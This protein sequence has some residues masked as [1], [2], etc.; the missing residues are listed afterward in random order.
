M[1]EEDASVK[2]RAHRLF[3]L[4]AVVAA[5]ALPAAAL[6][7]T[8]AGVNRGVVQSVDASHI[9]VTRPGREHDHVRRLAAA[10]RAPQRPPRLAGRDHAG[11]RGRRGRRP[12]GRAVLIRAFGAQAS[13]TERGIVTAVTKTSLTISTAAGPDDRPRPQY[14]LQGAGW[15]RQA[16]RRSGSACPSPSRTHPTAPRR[17]STCSSARGRDRRRSAERHD[18]SRRGRG[19]HRQPRP[20]ISRERRLPGDLG[21]ARR[22]GRA[23]ARAARD[24][25]RD[26]RPAAA[27]RGRA[28]PLPADPADVATS[29][30]DRH[31]PRRGGRPHHRARAR[32]RRLRDEALLAARARGARAR[33]AAPRR[34]GGA[35]GRDDDRRRRRAAVGPHRLRRRAALSS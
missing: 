17:S 7:A 11:T 30:R 10:R 8:H 18:P 6:A 27:G 23:G 24:P 25:A 35:R 4:A 16:R 1:I 33:R 31:R 29:D 2:T 9:V 12:K 28:R 19:R 15:C 14:A 26:P 32:R 21:G 5:L 13:T 20:R 34:A 22:R 3:A